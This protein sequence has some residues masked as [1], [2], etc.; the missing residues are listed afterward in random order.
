MQ[1]VS[2]LLALGFGF[3]PVF[4][5]AGEGSYLQFVAPGVIAMAILHTSVLSGISLIWDRQIGFLKAALV[6]PVPRI[7]LLIG[8]TL[9]GATVAVLQ[10]ILMSLASLLAGFRVQWTTTLPL[11]ILFVLLIAVV[12]VAFGITIGLTLHHM[13]G[14]Q[15]FMSLVI[16]PIFFLSGALFPLSHLPKVLTLLSMLNPLTYGVDGLRTALIG[17]QQFDVFRD[18]L[19][20]TSTAIVAL[21]LGVWRFSRIEI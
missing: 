1:P 3:E 8:R 13:Q 5:K 6:A 14:F 21:A 11:A 10:G 4:Q 16:L 15:L 7:Q 20:L 2:Y 9:G 18:L 17:Q 19:V 12:F